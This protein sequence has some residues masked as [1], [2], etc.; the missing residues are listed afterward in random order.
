MMI[1]KMLHIDSFSKFKIE[2]QKSTDKNFKL[3]HYSN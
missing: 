3:E 1:Y 2:Y